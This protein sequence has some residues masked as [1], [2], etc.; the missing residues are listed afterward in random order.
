MGGK[1]FVAA[2]NHFLIAAHCK[3]V[4]VLV[5]L[6]FGC[7]NK[8]DRLILRSFFMLAFLVSYL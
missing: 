7:F 5:A 6:R 2:D 8:L 4:A 3:K 1:I